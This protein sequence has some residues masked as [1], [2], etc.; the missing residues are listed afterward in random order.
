MKFNASTSVREE[1]RFISTPPRFIS[2]QLQA[3]SLWD[4]RAIFLFLHHFT[5]IV[6]SRLLVKVLLCHG[7]AGDD[8]AAF[9]SALS[10]YFKAG[11]WKGNRITGRERELTMMITKTGMSTYSLSALNHMF[12]PLFLAHIGACSWE[13]QQQYELSRI[14]QKICWFA[15]QNKSGLFPKSIVSL[16]WSWKPF[17]SRIGFH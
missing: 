1:L 13:K 7:K 11:H 17:V 12:R 6:R 10:V 3:C 8:T 15:L 2:Q 14:F 9:S 16:R 5:A 4:E